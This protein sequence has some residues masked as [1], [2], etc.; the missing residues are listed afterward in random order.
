MIRT[1]RK[2]GEKLDFFSVGHVNMVISLSNEDVYV[3]F[4]MLLL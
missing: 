4:K 3:N 1:L 2:R